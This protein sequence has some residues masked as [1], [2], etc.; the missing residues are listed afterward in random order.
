MTSDD[1][2]IFRDDLAERRRERDRDR[3]PRRFRRREVE[4][5]AF[6]VA[7][8]CASVP[9]ECPLCVGPVFAPADSH[10]ERIDCANEG[11]EARLVTHRSIGGELTALLLPDGAP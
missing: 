9:L 6:N 2:D 7:I 5:R 10:G 3:D 1:H 11:C 4:R 8:E